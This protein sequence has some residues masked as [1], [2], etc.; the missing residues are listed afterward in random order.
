MYDYLGLINTFAVGSSTTWSKSPYML[1]CLNSNGSDKCY[2]LVKIELNQLY[3][4]HQSIGNPSATTPNT[5]LERYHASIGT[6]MF[7]PV[8][9][10]VTSC[11]IVITIRINDEL[12]DSASIALEWRVVLD[13]PW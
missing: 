8:S 6:A 7:D 9:A 10:N 5:P 2:K 11:T 3:W 4:L 12:T 13:M 1:S